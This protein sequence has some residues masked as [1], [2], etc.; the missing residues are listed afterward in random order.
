M[1]P[2]VQ[3]ILA[4]V[5]TEEHAPAVNNEGTSDEVPI[6]SSEVVHSSAAT[7]VKEL[8]TEVKSTNKFM[9]EDELS[10]T[11]TPK[12]DRKKRRL[13]TRVPSRAYNLMSVVDLRE[14]CR[15]WRL[16]VSGKKEVLIK[17]LED[18]G[19][20]KGQLLLPFQ[21]KVPDLPTTPGKRSRKEDSSSD[22]EDSQQPS[23]KEMKFMKEGNRIQEE[24]PALTPPLVSRHPLQEDNCP[25]GAKDVQ[26]REIAGPLSFPQGEL[27]QKQQSNSSKQHK[28]QNGE[29]PSKLRPVHHNFIGTTP[30]KG[31]PTN[32]RLKSP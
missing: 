14:E 12:P 16:H 13:L 8:K 15:F 24:V 32:H 10:S 17:R 3:E 29:S 23:Q 4:T 19:K 25:G 20:E 1:S 26:G 18:N 2:V 28:Q 21:I 30:S 7:E 5:S 22:D 9:E 6:T 11:E 31:S 27:S